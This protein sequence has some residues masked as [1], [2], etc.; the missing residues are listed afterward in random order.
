M[1]WQY[2]VQAFDPA[3]ILD[4]VKTSQN[5]WE[6]IAYAGVGQGVPNCR[7][8]VLFRKVVHA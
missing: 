8:L 7:V 2:Y 3:D 5:G 6:P 4:N 1:P